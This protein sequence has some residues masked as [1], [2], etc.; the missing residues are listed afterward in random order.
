LQPTPE[1]AA[2]AWNRR[3]AEIAAAVR[4]AARYRHVRLRL[5]PGEVE[6]AVDTYPGMAALDMAVCEEHGKQ[7]DATIDAAMA[8]EGAG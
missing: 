1:I 5:W 7:I 3:N 4:D 2:Y 6:D 8:Q